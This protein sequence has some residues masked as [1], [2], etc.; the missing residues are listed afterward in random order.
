VAV[1]VFW[2]LKREKLVVARDADLTVT[3]MVT[4][5]TVSAFS[6]ALYTMSMGPHFA[7]LQSHFNIP[8]IMPLLVMVV[9][10]IVV[11]VLG[12][13]YIKKPEPSDD[14]APVHEALLS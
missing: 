4:H 9:F 8:N 5:S 2:S 7:L 6:F 3:D 11:W 14:A 10:P 1:W 13:T 12:D